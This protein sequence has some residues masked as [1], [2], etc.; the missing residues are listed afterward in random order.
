VCVCVHGCVCLCVCMC[1]QLR[2]ELVAAA[3]ITAASRI[4]CPEQ[5]PIRFLEQTATICRC[6]PDDILMLARDILIEVLELE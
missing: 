2:K 4:M 5:Y 6:V 1:V 3:V